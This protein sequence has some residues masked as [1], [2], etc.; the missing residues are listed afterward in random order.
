M[1][2]SSTPALGPP[3]TSSPYYSTCL[4]RLSRSESPSPS[5]SPPSSPI[6]SPRSLSPSRRTSP[7]TLSSA[8]QLPPPGQPLTSE[9]LRRLVRS[10]SSGFGVNSGLTVPD[11]LDLVRRAS[12]ILSHERNVVTVS[13]AHAVHVMGDIHGQFDDLCKVCSN[14]RPERASMIFA[15]DYVDR[16]PSGVECM[17]LLLALKVA[18]PQ[19]IF[20]LRG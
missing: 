8:L 5:H 15:G 12:A 14:M 9:F 10:L 1:R 6:S 3:E 7:T 18:Y 17:I 11:A 16:G 19:S 20:L 13:P 4:P 2:R